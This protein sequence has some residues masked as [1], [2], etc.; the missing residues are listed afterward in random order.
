[1]QGEDSQIVLEL[2]VDRKAFKVYAHQ[3]KQE[4]EIIP[5]LFECDNKIFLGW[6]GGGGVE[7]QEEIKRKI[8]TMLVSGGGSGVV[9][10]FVV[11][12]WLFIVT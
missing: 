8:L 1:M 11:M 9:V 4:W 2:Y 12:K 5:L 3:I 6:R 10:R 7:G